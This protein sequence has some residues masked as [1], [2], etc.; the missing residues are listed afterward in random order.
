[1]ELVLGIAVLI[2]FTVGITEVIKRLGLPSKF[3]PLVSLIVG[4]GLAILALTDTMTNKIIT[5]IMCGLSA[6]G[7]YSGANSTIKEIT[8]PKVEETINNNQ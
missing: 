8:K 6:S 3:S 2:A 5:G 4:I 1:M 7:L